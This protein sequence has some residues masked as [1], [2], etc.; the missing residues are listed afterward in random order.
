MAKNKRIKILIVAAFVFLAIF[1]GLTLY[2]YYLQKQKLIR[3]EQLM[4]DYANCLKA[5]RPDCGKMPIL[6]L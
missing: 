4:R 5:G 2:G 3:Y 1:T 6:G